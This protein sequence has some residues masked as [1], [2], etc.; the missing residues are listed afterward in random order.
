[1][2]KTT[3][4]FD[5]DLNSPAGIVSSNRPSTDALCALERWRNSSY[6]DYKVLDDT[7]D[8]LV[9]QLSFD[10][11]DERAAADLE[12]ESEI[13]GIERQFVRDR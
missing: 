9:A 13:S 12:T 7:D 11:N 5:R 8:F 1:M 10:Q 3:Y 6:R 2:Y 4:R